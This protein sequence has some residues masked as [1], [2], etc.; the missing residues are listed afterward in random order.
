M[1][2]QTIVNVKFGSAR[3]RLSTAVAAITLLLL[4]TGLSSVM[5][6]I[7]MIALAAVMMVVAV[8]TFDWRSVQLST[9]KRMP[10]TETATMAATVAV[11]AA[12]GNLAIG[13]GVGVLLAI[14]CFARRAAHVWFGPSACW[15]SINP[16][17]VTTC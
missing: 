7:P 14:L 5:A 6:E 8:K 10:V 13:V 3:T 16:P 2:G 17:S 12:T 11:T 15:R 1:I 4:V 9:L